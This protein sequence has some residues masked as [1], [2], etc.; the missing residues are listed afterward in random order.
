MGKKV[1]RILWVIGFFMLGSSFVATITLVS[2]V[3]AS[4]EGTINTWSVVFMT[5]SLILTYVGLYLR[6]KD[7]P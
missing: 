3:D 5:F 6:F 7:E 1:S 4:M 2:R